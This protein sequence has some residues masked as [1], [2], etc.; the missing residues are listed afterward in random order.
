MKKGQNM[1]KT[2]L[3]YL[4]ANLRQDIEDLLVDPS[5]HD[6]VKD[7][8]RKG[9]IMDGLDAYRDA[10]LAADILKKVNNGVY[11]YQTLA[12]EKERKREESKRRG[13]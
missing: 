10:Q 11:L 2:N 6:F 13:S 1:Q 8:I 12:Q 4:P 9:L 3:E 7:I 5:I